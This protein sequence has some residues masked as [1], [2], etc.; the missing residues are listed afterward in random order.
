MSGQPESAKRME[1]W[2]AEVGRRI[3]ARRLECGISQSQLGEKLAKHLK[4]PKTCNNLP[5]IQFHRS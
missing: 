3:R 1:N 4:L 5:Q 2:N